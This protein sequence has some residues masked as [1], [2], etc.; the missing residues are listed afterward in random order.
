MI[1]LLKY[2]LP[3]FEVKIEKV[4]MFPRLVILKN[5]LLYLFFIIGV[6]GLL[7]VR[8]LQYDHVAP[9][10]YLINLINFLVIVLLYNMLTHLSIYEPEV[11]LYDHFIEKNSNAE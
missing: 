1:R 4:K 3:V 7:F 8:I 6:Y 11:D 2:Q 5:I 10:L 9:I